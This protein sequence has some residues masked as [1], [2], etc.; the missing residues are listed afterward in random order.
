MPVVTVVGAAIVESDPPRVLA[1]CRAAP[2]ELA[3]LWEFPGGKVEP[4]ET[5]EQALVREC[6]EEL[7]VEITVGERLGTEVQLGGGTAV[8]RVHLARI[9]RGEPVAHEHAEVRWLSAD[10]LDS[11]PWIPV[12]RPLVAALRALLVSASPAGASAT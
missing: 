2:P 4:G 6:R 8:L 7:G 12:D 3:G 1:A 9:T 5:D 11:V 10:E